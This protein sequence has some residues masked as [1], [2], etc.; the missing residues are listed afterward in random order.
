ML[1]A[2]LAAPPAPTP[3]AASSGATIS[4]AADQGPEQGAEVAAAT[5][6]GGP[7]FGRAADQGCREQKPEAGE[8]KAD[9]RRRVAVTADLGRLRRAGRARAPIRGALE[10]R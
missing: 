9:V 7:P 5:G 3:A 4:A 1:L 8:G 10:A 2:V 6:R